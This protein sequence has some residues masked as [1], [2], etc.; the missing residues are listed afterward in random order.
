MVGKLFVQRHCPALAGA[1]FLRHRKTSVL[2][3]APLKK[4]SQTGGQILL[5]LLTTGPILRDI[6]EDR[7]LAGFRLHAAVSLRPL[8][9]TDP[10]QENRCREPAIL[11]ALNEVCRSQSLA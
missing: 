1:D 3:R 11:I 4:G 7:N 8:S 6:V 2:L 5:K 10:A 9:S